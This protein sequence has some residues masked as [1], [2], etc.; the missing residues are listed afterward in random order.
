[1]PPTD[2]HSRS[3]PLGVFDYMKPLLCEKFASG[4]ETGNRGISRI[5][6][7][8]RCSRD[9]RFGREAFSLGRLVAN[10]RPKR[11]PKDRSK[12]VAKGYCV[13]TVL[14]SDNG[15]EILESVA[16]IHSNAEQNPRDTPLMDRLRLLSRSHLILSSFSYILPLEDNVFC[17]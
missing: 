15:K 5:A 17:T 8:S 1:M 9:K 4:D 10:K 3:L 7:T 6:P 13:F 16:L 12:K 14:L 11:T 2:Q